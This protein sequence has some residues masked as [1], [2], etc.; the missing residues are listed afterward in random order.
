MPLRRSRTHQLVVSAHGLNLMQDNSNTIKK[1]EIVIDASNQVELEANTEKA[2]CTLM[3][4]RDNVR[5]NHYMKTVNRTFENLVKL[6]Y[7]VTTVTIQNCI[8]Y[9]LRGMGA[10]RNAYRVLVG[11]PEGKRPQGGPRYRWVDNIKM[12]LRKRERDAMDW[13][14]REQER[15]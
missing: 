1:T 7:S 6:K 9:K 13:I 11:K 2:K 5:K 15:D 12:D 3:S 4:P 14:D 8:Y 10:K